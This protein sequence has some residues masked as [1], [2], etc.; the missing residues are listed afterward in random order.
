VIAI[1]DDKIEFI[2]TMTIFVTLAK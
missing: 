1:V 2:K